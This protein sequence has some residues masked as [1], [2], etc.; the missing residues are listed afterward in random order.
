MGLPNSQ[1]QILAAIDNELQE[2][3]SLAA[4]FSAFTDVTQST[5]MPAAEQ[6]ETSN[7]PAGRRRCRRRGWRNSSAN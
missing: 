7:S 4:A 3:Q 5:D 2:D 6:L 1:L